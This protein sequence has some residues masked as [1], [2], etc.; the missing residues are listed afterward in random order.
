MQACF[1]DAGFWQ[2]CGAT[3]STA[4]ISQHPPSHLDYGYAHTAAELVSLANGG[5]GTALGLGEVAEICARGPQIALGY[6]R[7]EA[8]TCEAFD[9]DGLLH[10]SDRIKEMIKVK[11][12]QTAPAEL[13]AVLMGHPEVDACAVVGV[14]D[15][16]T[17]ER[18]KASVVS[19]SGTVPSEMLGRDLLELIKGELVR[20]NMER[21]TG[22]KKGISERNR[23]RGQASGS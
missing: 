2:G 11:G 9:A 16:Y 6:L 10:I 21:S 18:P 5:G 12:I 7:D 4:C 8:A 17:G 3:E 20:H 13:E 15:D 14:L 23:I 19:R 22:R 1:P